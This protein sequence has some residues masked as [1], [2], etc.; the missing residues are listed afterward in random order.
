M[1]KDIDLTKHSSFKFWTKEI[2]RFA[3]LDALNH[4]NNIASA[5][6]CE[7]ARVE[8]FTQK[9][10]HDFSGNINW[11]LANINLNYLSPVNYPNNISIG[12]RIKHIG[13]SSLIMEQGLFA[14]DHCFSTAETTLV[15]VDLKAGKS[16]SFTQDMRDCF[17]QYF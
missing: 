13:N 1:S 14:D 2:F 8:F 16:T 15:Y 5:V 11:V 6:Y 17:Q 7:T 4:L 3:D 9:L 12:T 10:G